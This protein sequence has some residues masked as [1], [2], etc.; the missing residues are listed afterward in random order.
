MGRSG[1]WIYQSQFV[2]KQSPPPER[3]RRTK[4]AFSRS[5]WRREYDGKSISLKTGSMYREPLVTRSC[6]SPIKAP[7]Q[8]SWGLVSWQWLKGPFSI[9]QEFSLAFEPTSKIW[10]LTDFYMKI[11]KIRL[12]LIRVIGVQHM[13]RTSDIGKIGF[14]A[15]NQITRL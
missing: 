12:N 11:R 7:L 5:R 13:D 8:K 4:R 1:F 10:R 15:R 6:N 14:Y 3:Q 9:Y 2:R